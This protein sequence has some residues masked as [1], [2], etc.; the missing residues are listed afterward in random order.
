MNNQVIV[1]EHNFRKESKQHEKMFQ[2]DPVIVK[3]EP[4][5][6]SDV[7]IIG[8]T[9]GHIES[10]TPALVDV[11]EYID[12][13]SLTSLIGSGAKE[14]LPP[15]VEKI[16]KNLSNDDEFEKEC[17]KYYKA[18]LDM[19]VEVVTVDVAKVLAEPIK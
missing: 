10:T 9:P 7:E 18:N 17:D 13:N 14:E 11:P 8:S 16:V 6:D 1:G 2:I 4:E 12:L 15:V 3:D 5:S 19:D